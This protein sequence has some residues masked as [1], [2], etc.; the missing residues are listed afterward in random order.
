MQ[1]LFI[2]FIQFL[3]NWITTEVTETTPSFFV[4]TFGI[5][6]IFTHRDRH[7]GV[8]FGGHAIFKGVWMSLL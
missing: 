6:Q 3:N 5:M 4:W 2:H 7:V 8:C 1:F